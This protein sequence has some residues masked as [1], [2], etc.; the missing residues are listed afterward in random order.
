MRSLNKYS[1][2]NSPDHLQKLIR[3]ARTLEEVSVFED[4]FNKTISSLKNEPKG[5]KYL[6]TNVLVFLK[7]Q[8]SITERK[9]ELVGK[10]DMLFPDRPKPPKG[11]EF[12]AAIRHNRLHS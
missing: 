8:K 1:E 2:L 5:R 12:F 4:Q 10:K 11:G 3:K 7:I 6:K 9:N